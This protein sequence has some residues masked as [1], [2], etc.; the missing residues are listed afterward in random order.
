MKKYTKPTNNDYNKLHEISK[1]VSYLHGIESLL[2]WDQETYMPPGGAEYRSHLIKTI[3]GITH[4]K[5]VSSTF[6]NALSK[7]INVDKGK[8]VGKNLSE[9][10]QAALR[11]WRKDFLRAKA[12]PQAFV[13]KWAKETSS[14][15]TAWRQAKKESNFG[16][17]L[18][19]LKTIVEMS[20]QKADY[21]GYDD[22]PYDALMDLYEGG[23]SVATITPLFT[24]LRK[25]IVPL[26]NKIKAEKPADDSFLQGTWSHEKQLEFGKKV[27]DTM[28]YDF[29]YGRIDLSTHPFSS[30]THPTDSRITTRFHDTNLVS[31]VSVIMHEG[32]HSLYA[33]GLPQEDFGSPLGEAISM[34]MHESQSR[35]WEIYVGQN[36]HFWAHYLP[37]LKKSFPGK[38]DK[39]TLDQFYKAVNKVTPSLIRVEADE[40]TY[41]LHVILRYDLEKRL[42]EG[43]LA[44]KD[45]P[46]AWNA[47]MKQLLG[48]VP[49]NDAEGC[50]QDIHW[51]MGGFGYFPSYTLG[52]MYAAQFFAA[53]AKQHPDWAKRVEAGD[54]KFIREWLCTNIHRYGRQYDSPTL[55]EKVTGKPFTANAYLA[56]LKSK[57]G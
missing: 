56:H 32:G 54:L 9:R 28:G 24:T 16:K 30:G 55:I 57:Y 42:M 47:N 25:E 52:T 31:C 53:F 34:G 49:K 6:K 18:P 33:M 39:V 35:F 40:V 3:A 22:H 37:L 41:P 13:E 36:K 11:E 19:H 4:K 20:R 45:V 21:L 2:D 27:L 26:L 17:F 5:H 23:A 1:E 50:L 7:L 12:L 43:S 10:Q 29:H 48:V 38:L 14:S 44:P 51:S 15:I 46:E 8:I